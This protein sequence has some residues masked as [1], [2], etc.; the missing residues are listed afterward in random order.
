MQP[1]DAVEH[2]TGPRVVGVLREKMNID[3]ETELAS[4]VASFR[5]AAQAD[6]NAVLTEHLRKFDLQVEPD[7]LLEGTIDFVVATVALAAM[8]GRSIEGF[9]DSQ[10]YHPNTGGAATYSVTFDL[11]GRGVARVMS[12]PR[13]VALDLADLYAMP[14]DR[15][16]VVGYN[17]FWVS[18]VDHFDLSPAELDRL[19]EDV[20]ADLRFDYG[21]DE[22]DFWFDRDTYRG[23]MLV[24]VQDH[25]DL[26]E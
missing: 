25:V 26:D 21:E 9:L 5:S 4:W 7:L 6:V 11:F 3:P 18:R 20:A 24:F 16:R 15:Y 23:A 17:R 8:D 14:W 13:L 1:R 19:E 10:R 22:L 12:D 2:V